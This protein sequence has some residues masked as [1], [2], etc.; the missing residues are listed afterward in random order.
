METNRLT[1]V[2]LPRYTYASRQADAQRANFQRDGLRCRTDAGAPGT[3]SKRFNARKGR[4]F[5]RQIERRVEFCELNNVN[6]DV[7]PCSVGAGRYRPRRIA[8][9]NLG[10]DRIRAC[11]DNI[12]KA[13]NSVQVGSER[14][15][16]SGLTASAQKRSTSVI[17]AIFELLAVS[18]T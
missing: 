7:Y 18:R 11:V 17:C 12:N 1:P 15:L 8:D 5:R 10:R 14:T 4:E 2:T 6:R 3:E 13:R 16:P 9:G